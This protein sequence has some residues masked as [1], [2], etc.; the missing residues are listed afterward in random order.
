[1]HANPL[2]M[3]YNSSP[4]FLLVTI[5]TYWFLQYLWNIVVDD[6]GDEDD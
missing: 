6:E 2:F 5:L 4:F 1:M 3:T